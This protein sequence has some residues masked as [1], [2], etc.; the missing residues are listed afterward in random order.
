M[1]HSCVCFCTGASSSPAPMGSTRSVGPIIFMND[2]FKGPLNEQSTRPKYS[3]GPQPI[4]FVTVLPVTYYRQIMTSGRFRNYSDTVMSEQPWF[5][6]IQSKAWQS[7]RRKA[8]SISD[9]RAPDHI[10]TTI[11]SRYWLQQVK[12]TETTTSLLRHYPASSFLWLAE[13]RSLT[14]MLHKMW[15]QNGIDEVSKGRGLLF[16]EKV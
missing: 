7:K 6:R 8:R 14:L 5:T 2:M 13:R 10:H 12:S 4:R 3:S 9:F 15:V 11:W 1:F 16:K